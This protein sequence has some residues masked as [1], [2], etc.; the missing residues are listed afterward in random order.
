MAYSNF[1]LETVQKTFQL[2]TVRSKGLFSEIEPVMPSAY[3]T[4]GLEKKAPLATAIGTEKVRSELIVADMIVELLEHFDYRISFFSGIE[5]NVDAEK[6]LTGVCDFLVSLSPEQFYLEAPIIVL[7]EAK[8]LDL[9][10]GIGQCVA[11]MLA[12]QRF[13]AEKGNEIPCIYGASTTGVDWIFL[14]LEEKCLHIDMTIYQIAQCDRILGIL[15][16]MVKLTA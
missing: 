7:V 1:T 15:S 16:S 6:G 9:K 10:L 14:K 2:D 11:E 13:N 4:T 3:L 5:F 12:A 8:N